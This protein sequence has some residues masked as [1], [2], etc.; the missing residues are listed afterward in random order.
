MKENAY[1]QMVTD[2]VR[3]HFAE[4]IDLICAYGSFVRGKM[5]EKSD[6]DLFFV[7]STPR[8]YQASFQ[9]IIDDIGYDFF[10]ISWDR[11]KAIANYDDPLTSLILEG[12]IVYHRND[13]CFN[14][15]EEI[16]SYTVHFQRFE[17]KIPGLIDEAKRLFFEYPETLPEILIKC[18]MA[19]A[20]QNH[21]PL[22][23]GMMDFENEL[24]PLELPPLFLENIKFLIEEPTRSLAHKMI[25]DTEE[26]VTKKVEPVVPSK[27]GFYEELKSIYQKGHATTSVYKQYFITHL[28][29]KETKAMFPNATGFPKAKS[30]FSHWLHAHE[31]HLLQI[32]E[33]ENIPIREYKSMEDFETLF[34]KI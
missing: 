15:F 12:Q 21:T 23:R 6:I 34:L 24:A 11:L 2:Y 32:L 27:S 5:H 9:V 18:A 30:P 29:E 25:L 20:Y 33:E 13:A 8:G 16:R 7:P 26:F 3:H 19:V 28:I 31:K 22:R 1:I 14:R 10:P 17:E 4:D